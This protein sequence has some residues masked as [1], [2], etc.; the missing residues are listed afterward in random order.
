MSLS[1]YIGE[2]KFIWIRKMKVRLLLY[3]K[4]CRIFVTGVG[5]FL[6]MIKTIHFGYDV[7][8]LSKKKSKT[9]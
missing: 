1:L 7:R 9:N 5:L 6:M 3:T 8:V 4:G 2:G